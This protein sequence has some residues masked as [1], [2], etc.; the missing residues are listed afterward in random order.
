MKAEGI[1]STGEC[2]RFR[3]EIAPTVPPVTPNHLQR[4]CRDNGGRACWLC[5]SQCVYFGNGLSGGGG[6][7]CPDWHAYSCVTQHPK[8]SLTG[9]ALTLGALEG[10]ED[11]IHCPASLLD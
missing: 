3:R 11:L 10:A 2:A 4:S 6:S 5:H 1:S 9:R 8:I 7:E